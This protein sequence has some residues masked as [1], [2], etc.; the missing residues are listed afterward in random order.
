MNKNFNLNRIGLLARK[1]FIEEYKIHLMFLVG[2]A[3]ILF[4]IFYFM[5]LRVGFTTID[6]GHRV[7]VLSFTLIVGG[8][9]YIGSSFPA[10]RGKNNS[11][12]YLLLP[13]TRI[14][15]LFIEYVNRIILF[16]LVTPI[17]YWLVANAELAF[18]STISE[19]L[20][21]EYLKLRFFPPFL[22]DSEYNSVLLG[23]VVV[24]L[25]LLMI[26]NSAFIGAIVFMKHPRVKTLFRISIALFIGS[27]LLFSIRTFGIELLR[28]IINLDNILTATNAIRLTKFCVVLFLIVN[29]FMMWTSYKKIKEKV[30]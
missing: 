26:Y 25:F 27:L 5:H 3:G 10:F 9:L 12:T 4:L 18:A 24:M 8:F 22:M 23:D 19:N 16:M 28:Q 6:F 30:V 7:D 29:L 17:I 21:Y 20:E 13:A 15:K 1:Y 11:M 2:M 14:E